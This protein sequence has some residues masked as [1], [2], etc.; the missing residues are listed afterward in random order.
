MVEHLA[1]RARD[2]RSQRSVKVGLSHREG[3]RL[4]FR[5]VS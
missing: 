1:V 4:Q 5:I 3:W 2:E